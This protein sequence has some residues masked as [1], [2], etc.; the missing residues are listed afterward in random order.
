MSAE[1]GERGVALAGR[2][3]RRSASTRATRTNLAPLGGGVQC[4]EITR[5]II[6]YSFASSELMK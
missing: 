1:A 2:R 4:S 5:S 3:D 6:P